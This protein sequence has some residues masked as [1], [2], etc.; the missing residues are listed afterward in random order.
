MD[1]CWQ[2]EPRAYNKRGTLRAEAAQVRRCGT[3]VLSEG[4][5]KRPFR[6][7]GLFLRAAPAPQATILGSTL[8][9]GK[10]TCVVANASMACSAPGAATAVARG[11]GAETLSISSIFDDDP[12]GEIQG[13]KSLARS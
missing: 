1:L 3:R 11:G 2:S 9:L 7:P 6:R 8:A 4:R 13:L 5:W 12:D 10:T